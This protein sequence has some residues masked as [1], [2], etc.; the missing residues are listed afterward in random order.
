MRILY[1]SSRPPKHSAGLAMGQMRSLVEAGHQ[2]DFLTKYSFE[3]Q[4]S[5]MYS[6]YEK[7]WI[8]KLVDLRQKY[9]KLHYLTNFK[10]IVGRKN[11]TFNNGIKLTAPDESQPPVPVEDVLNCIKKE[12]DLVITL[13]LQDFISSLTLKAIYEKLKCPIIIRSVDMEPFT[14]GCYFF[15]DC[16]HYQHNCGKCPALKSDN[17]NDQTRR[18]FLIKK[19]SYASTNYAY[20]C[21]NWMKRFA[22]KSNMFEPDRIFTTTAV[23]DENKFFQRPIEEC[24]IVFGIPQNKTFILFARYQNKAIVS[25]GFSHLID[26]VNEWGKGI[27]EE[28]KSKILLLI[29]GNRD[30]DPLYEMSVET[31][32]LG[33]L[34]TENLIR[35]YSVATAFIS[36]SIDDAGPSM[37][38][39][40]I[41]CSTPV[42]SYNIGTAIDVIE[43]GKSGFKADEVD[44]HRLAECIQKLY[45]M[46][47]EEYIEL[48]KTTRAIAM[49]KHSLKSFAIF[50]ERV[51]YSIRDRG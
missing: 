22:L 30:S 33:Q 14:G 5:N 12:Y 47:E 19:E 25:K 23:V 36:P 44:A 9:P 41:M 49:E 50:T 15:L 48:R 4:E 51:Y 34:D 35:A 11:L 29:A 31:K 3:G 8:D 42:I 26:A 39:Q 13:F 38:N 20:C 16:D 6:I 40:S 1:I 37:V 24:R 10:F 28:D 45:S 32:Y 46:S 7:N 18:N 17:E 43:N 27:S 21:N 2:V